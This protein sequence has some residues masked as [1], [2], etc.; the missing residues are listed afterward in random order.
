[1]NAFSYLIIRDRVFLISCCDSN[2]VYIVA[3]DN[4]EGHEEGLYVLIGHFVG[5][6]HGVVILGGQGELGT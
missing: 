1:M 4:L 2:D 5:H 6:G 3:S